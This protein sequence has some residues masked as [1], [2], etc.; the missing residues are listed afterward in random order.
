MYTA[1]LERM[2]RNGEGSSDRYK[3]DAG[4]HLENTEQTHT[5]EHKP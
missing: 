1:E 3:V 2:Q 5:T 4:I